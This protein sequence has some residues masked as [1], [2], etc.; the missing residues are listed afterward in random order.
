MFILSR[1]LQNQFLPGTTIVLQ[2]TLGTLRNAGASFLIRKFDS[3]VLRL[4]YMLWLEENQD[5][6]WEDS[7][8][9]VIFYAYVIAPLSYGFSALLTHKQN[10]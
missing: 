1:R 7:F 9:V 3:V 4:S 8:C 6:K 5:F 10:T 2:Y